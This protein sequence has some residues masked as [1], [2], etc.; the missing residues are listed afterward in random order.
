[1][2]YQDC[3]H[4]RSDQNKQNKAFSAEETAGSAQE[5]VR[6]ANTMVSPSVYFSRLADIDVKPF[7]SS[8]S[9]IS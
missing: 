6:K 4:A 9:R 8:Y 7:T 1:M 2:D 3:R 5:I